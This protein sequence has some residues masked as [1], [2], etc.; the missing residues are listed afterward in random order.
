MAQETK[1]AE[2]VALAAVV[3][4]QSVCMDAANKERFQN[5]YAPAYVEES[6]DCLRLQRLVTAR[7]EASRD[8]K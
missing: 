5:G 3:F 1:D 8:E 7:E 4:H 6:D 2:L